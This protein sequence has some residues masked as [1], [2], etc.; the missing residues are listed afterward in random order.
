MR[1]SVSASTMDMKG[2]R[3]GLAHRGLASLLAASLAT[4]GCSQIGSIRNGIFDPPGGAAARRQA[5]GF[6]GGAVADEPQAALVAR[7]VLSSGGNAADAAVALAFALSVTLPSR[8]G[9]GGGGGCVVYSAGRE[10]A[11]RNG[12]DGAPKRAA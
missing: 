6:L 11:G 1:S 3:P 7:D 9:L 2:K 4:S 12:A 10:G 8:A 5:N